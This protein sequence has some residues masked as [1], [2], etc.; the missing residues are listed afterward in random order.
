MYA[1]VIVHLSDVN[2][3]PPLI[4][5]NTLETTHHG[6]DGGLTWVP[7]N[8][9]GGS[10]IAHVAVTDRD[11]ALNAGISC[12]L[13][14]GSATTF[15][16]IQLGHN[17]FKVISTMTFDREQQDVYHVIITCKVRFHKP[18]SEDVSREILMTYAN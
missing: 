3:N 8:V 17:E 11:S 12:R 9:G 2:D 18:W 5:I 16:L 13:D 10:F 4:A 7:E 6:T 15:Q 1:V 14:N